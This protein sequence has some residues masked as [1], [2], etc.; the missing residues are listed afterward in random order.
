[1]DVEVAYIGLL[2]R[3]GM[4]SRVDGRSG[5]ESGYGE[6]ERGI[7][8]LRKEKWMHGERGL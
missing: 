6:S 5:M 8:L 7:V 2:F 3:H 4:H 1:M